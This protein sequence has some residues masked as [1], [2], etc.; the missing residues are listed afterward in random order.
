MPGQCIET[1]VPDGTWRYVVTARLHAWAGPASEPSPAVVVEPP[2]VALRPA[3]AA[4]RGRRLEAVTL[5][6][7]GAG[8]PVSLTLEPGAIALAPVVAGDDGRLVVDVDLPADLADGEL[9]I[10]A[11][12][13]WG[14]ER[15]RT[16]AFTLDTVAPTSQP[17]TAL[18]EWIGPD[19]P[20][21]I[22]ASDAAPSSGVRDVTWQLDGDPA[23]VVPG[24]SAEL[25]LAA[26]GTLRWFA[27]D[28]AGNVEATNETTVQVD[29]RPPTIAEFALPTTISNGVVLRSVPT[30]AESGVASVTY[31]YCAGAECTPNIP[32]GGAVGAPYAIPWITQP[33]NGPYRVV[34]SARDRAGNVTRSEPIAVTVDNVGPSGSLG[35]LPAVVGSVVP[36]TA[37]ATDAQGV[38]SVAFE[39][40][41]DGGDWVAI[42]VVTEGVEHVYGTIWDTRDLDPGVYTVRAVATDVGGTSSVFPSSTIR[43]YGPS[44]LVLSNGGGAPGVGTIGRGDRIAVR[45]SAAP[46]LIA[47]C[48][49][50]WNTSAPTLAGSVT[51]TVEDGGEGNDRIRITSSACGAT[52]GNFGTL[53]LGSPGHVGPAGAAFSG[54]GARAS[55]I[56]WDATSLTLTVTFGDL[57]AGV[58]APVTVP[59]VA[60]Y[61]MSP[62][63][64]ATN[65]A[66]PGGVARTAPPN[67]V[68]NF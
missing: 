50:A 66:V 10:E 30:D 31:L 21:T 37:T 6:G 24:A 27:T 56:V 8:E 55:S 42:A 52:G 16:A 39:Y 46:R 43:I 35:T 54:L 4:G 15:P 13:A 61:T 12:G 49:G 25:R 45:L 9:R 7:F 60:S 41:R 28:V 38:A 68:V 26:G 5:A 65:L 3:A 62:A 40:S 48:P 22:V 44:S 59:T 33:A 32:I 1:A 14:P 34:A 17:A 20:V 67:G 2:S 11:S 63:A 47:L 57:S 53:T 18:P 19:T 29:V 51:I 64:V 36:L 23:V 58:V